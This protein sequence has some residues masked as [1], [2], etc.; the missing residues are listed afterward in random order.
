MILRPPRSTPLYS[1][2]A[3]DVYKRQLKD[4][5]F[6]DTSIHL[7]DSTNSFVLATVNR[8]SANLEIDNWFNKPKRK[9]IYRSV[10][11]F[12]PNFFNSIHYSIDVGITNSRNEY[13]I[14]LN[15]VLGF[16]IHDTGEMKKEY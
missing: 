10:C 7:K 8:G 12:P 16:T 2:A 11:K 1:S 3:S 6:L 9:G 14:R 13:E 4:G 15:D 5:A